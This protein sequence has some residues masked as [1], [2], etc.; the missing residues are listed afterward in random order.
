MKDIH[1]AVID[2]A[3][4]IN[5]LE[6]V[7]EHESEAWCLF[8][9]PV[10]EAFAKVAPYLVLLTPELEQH[11]I[12]QEKPWGFLF[13]STEGNKVLVKHLRGLLSVMI[14]GHD[15]PS[16]FRYYDP[17]ILWSVMDSL[18]AR[19]QYF[20]AT[21]MKTIQTSYPEKRV[22][23][24]ELL[25]PM[26]NA[27]KHLTLNQAQY[28]AILANCSQNLEEDIA[29]YIHQRQAPER[30]DMNE[31]KAFAKQLA[32]QLTEWGITVASDIKAV[33]QHCMDNQIDQWAAVPNSWKAILAN[34]HLSASNRVKSLVMTQGGSNEL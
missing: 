26:H 2:K 18:E 19:Q 29:A 12:T 5:L 22:M 24:F 1:Y 28:T 23:H 14:E 33:A 6:L 9:A 20:L 32:Q 13:T 7:Q 3:V 30:K 34:Q 21:S 16:F 27:P 4:L 15:T 25:P 31:A 8:P 17:R 11:L 10:D